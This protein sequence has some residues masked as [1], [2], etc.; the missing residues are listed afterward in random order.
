[1]LTDKELQSLCSLGC[2]FE[3]AAEEIKALRKALSTVAQPVQ[4]AAVDAQLIEVLRGGRQC[5]EIGVEIIMSRQACLEAADIL[6]AIA[7]KA[8]P[9]Q[10]AGNKA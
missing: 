9:V 6:E 5:D 4:P 2:E 7:T 10:P 1:M 8:Q 3:A